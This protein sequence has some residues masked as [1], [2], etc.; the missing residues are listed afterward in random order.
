MSSQRTS[1]ASVASTSSPANIYRGIQIPMTDGT[2]LAADVYLPSTDDVHTPLVLEYIPYR[3]DDVVSSSTFYEQLLRAGYAVARVDVRGTGGSGGRYLDE[4]SSQEQQDGFDAVEWLAAQPFCDGRVSMIG[5]S[6]GGFTALQVA[7]LRPPHLTSIIPICFTHDRY[8]DDCHYKGGLMRC[9]YDVGLYGTM[10]TAWNAMPADPSVSEN[11]SDV[12]SQHI[13]E[14]EPALLQWLEHQIDG[15]YWREGSVV[16]VADRISC[17][18]FMIG[19]W[20]D[21]YTNPPL[22]LYPR[23]NC[24]KRLLMG[25]WN[26][27]FPDVAVPGPRIDFMR[28]VISWLDVWCRPENADAASAEATESLQF[29]MQ[30]AQPTDA[31]RLD[32]SGEWRGESQWPPRGGTS[33]T[34]YLGDGHL[35]RDIAHQ[36]QRLYAYDPTV[37]TNSGLWSAGVPFGLAGPQWPDEARSAV[38]TSEPLSEPFSIL[39]RPTL[40]LAAA[41][42]ARVMGFTVSLSEVLPTGHSNLVTKGALNGTRRNGWREPLPITP[43]E[44]M[45]LV[46]DLDATG[47]TFS[48][49]SRIR[50]SIASADWPNIWPTPELGTNTIIE[51]GSAGSRITFP[52]VPVDSGVWPGRL[53]PSDAQ[54]VSHADALDPPAWVVQRDL[55]TDVAGVSYTYSDRQRVKASKLISRTFEFETRCDPAEPAACSARGRHTMKVH[56]PLDTTEGTAEIVV[57]G[58]LSHFHVSVIVSIKINEMVHR[59]RSWTR[60]I[61]RRLL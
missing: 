18:V 41:S 32:S 60:S 47:W 9:Y 7:A 53:D 19:G 13:D 11:W 17:P 39:G 6:Y 28:E 27:S 37:G 54:V 59:S 25:P 5:I 43:G 38:Y 36:G 1:T 48:P 2:S 4:Y 23:L 24:R 50:V 20:R 14:N 45:S 33:Q 35:L 34:L 40:H 29:F 56:S 31:N 49:G 16:D 42:T 26:H 10:M 51:G 55:I 8:T 15:P 58:S 12:W 57:R 21:G 44:T 22:E 30:S 3:K 52:A 46:I 61:P